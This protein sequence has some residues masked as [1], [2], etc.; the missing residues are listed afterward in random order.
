[1]PRI[2]SQ[3]S[4]FSQANIID[5]SLSLSLAILCNCMTNSTKLRLEFGRRLKAMREKRGLSQD[6][7]AKMSGW[8]SNTRMSSYER[9]LNE[10][11]LDEISRLASALGIFPEV[12]AFGAENI[13]AHIQ[14][15]LSAQIVP[16][17]QSIEAESLEGNSSAKQPEDIDI[18]RRIQNDLNNL[19]GA[20]QR[21]RS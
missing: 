11:T 8:A 20:K 18:I 5:L 12:L 7:L 15:L 19:R 1:M 17:D 16:L 21:R 4:A 13:A 6:T 2:I 3:S 14:E 10:P 9:G